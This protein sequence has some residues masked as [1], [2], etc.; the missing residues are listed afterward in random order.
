MVSR[1]LL[2]A[3]LATTLAG[4]ALPSFAD[5]L[6]IDIGPPARRAERVEH[7]KGYVWA[8]GIWQYSNGKHE[9]AAGHLVAERKGYTYAPDRWVSNDHDKW[10]YQ[11]GGW[12]KDSDGDGT[13]DRLDN[14]PNNSHRQ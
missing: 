10:A 2:L 8:P 13:P 5:D 3:G 9:W 14:H 6:Y 7:R 11:R 1:K 12:N 4:F